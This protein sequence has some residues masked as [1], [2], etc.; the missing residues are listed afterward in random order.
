MGFQL[1]FSSDFYTLDNLVPLT[2]R[3]AGQAD[4]AIPVAMDHP[5]HLKDPDQ[6][7]GQVLEL[8]LIHI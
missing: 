5:P 6:A 7:G 2:L 3:I 8:S 1:D 4:Q